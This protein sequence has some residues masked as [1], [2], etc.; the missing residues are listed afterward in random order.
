MK[1]A[2]GFNLE[3]EKQMGVT[4]YS[5]SFYGEYGICDTYIYET[6]YR[7]GARNPGH[8]GSE[9]EDSATRAKGEQEGAATW[10][11]LSTRLV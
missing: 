1:Q 9:Q 2:G 4:S 5:S 3:T 7:V 10:V 6:V 11:L 8:I